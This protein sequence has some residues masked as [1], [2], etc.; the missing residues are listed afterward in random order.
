MRHF[1][2]ALGVGAILAS[3]VHSLPQD[4]TATTTASELPCKLLPLLHI[5]RRPQDSDI[6]TQHVHPSFNKSSPPTHGPNRAHNQHHLRST[7]FS[8][9]T[10]QSPWKSPM[11]PTQAL[12]SF[13][14]IGHR[15]TTRV[16]A[17]ECGTWAAMLMAWR[18][19]SLMGRAG[20]GL[21]RI[22][23]VII[24]LGTY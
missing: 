4:S 8:S 22:I 14:R 1:T 17:M 11:T 13:V 18:G 2:Q 9:R 15:I 5:S 6:C 7:T 23:F 10:T 16:I 20:Y 24:S 21:D 19:S 3:V 12:I